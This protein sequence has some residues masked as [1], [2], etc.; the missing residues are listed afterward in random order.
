M[1]NK[2]IFLWTCL[3]SM[4]YTITIFDSNYSLEIIQ[5]IWRILQK[6]PAVWAISFKN[7]WLMIFKAIYITVNRHTY[8]LP[9]LTEA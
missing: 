7:I 4:S 9:N 5:F 8:I 2:T 6:H 3:W 1:S